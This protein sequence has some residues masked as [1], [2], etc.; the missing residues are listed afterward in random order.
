MIFAQLALDE[1]SAPRAPTRFPRTRESCKGR[2]WLH[3]ARLVG[4]AEMDTAVRPVLEQLKFQ[5]ALVKA[6]LLFEACDRLPE[7]DKKALYEEIRQ[8]LFERIIHAEA[9]TSAEI[10]PTQFNCEPEEAATTTDPSGQPADDRA[11]AEEDAAPLPALIRA[12]IMRLLKRKSNRGVTPDMASHA[13]DFSSQ[14]GNN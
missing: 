11:S 14:A 13:K 12:P 6:D 2:A 9:P 1:A 7:A 4:L 10:S 5:V 8:R 3:T